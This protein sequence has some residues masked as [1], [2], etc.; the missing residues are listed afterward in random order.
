MRLFELLSKQKKGLYGLTFTDAVG[1]WS[2]AGTPL[3]I[4]DFV[5]HTPLPTTIKS[6]RLEE[7]ED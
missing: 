5:R 1:E 4:I 2:T 3:E 6:Y 7:L